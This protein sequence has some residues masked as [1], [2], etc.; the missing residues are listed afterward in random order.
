MI[1]LLQIKY[2]QML[3]KDFKYKSKNNNNINYY[4]NILYYNINNDYELIYNG[5]NNLILKKDIFIPLVNNI[6]DFKI[7]IFINNCDDSKN[8]IKEFTLNINSKN[9]I[10]DTTKIIFSKLCM[11]DENEYHDNTDELTK[12]R[13]ELNL[14]KL[15][16][17]DTSVKNNNYKNELN[18][19]KNII[20]E[21]INKNN[22]LNEINNNYKLTKENNSLLDIKKVNDNHKRKLLF[23]KEKINE[24]DE[25]I[26]H[27]S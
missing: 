12:I 4:C 16:L 2:I 24:I 1:K 25:Y 21:L 18:E 3:L 9:I 26:D 8:I 17:A 14:L 7:T 10:N 19:G 11:V 20:N 5:R 6:N 23:I 13:Y 22:K 15:K 27:N